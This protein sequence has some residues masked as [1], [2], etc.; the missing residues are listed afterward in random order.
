MN[1]RTVTAVHPATP[2]QQGF[3]LGTL[4]GRDA[5][6][7]EQSVFPL[8]GSLDRGQLDRA[9]SG[10]VA[11]HEILRTGFAWAL[12]GDPQQVVLAAG[13]LTPEY[14]DSRGLKPAAQRAALQQLLDRHRDAPFDLTRPPLLRL[15]VHRLND[16]RHQLVWTH[17]HVVLDGWSHLALA[18]ELLSRYAGAPGHRSAFGPYSRWL[19]CAD[20][21]TQTYW[22]KHLDGYRGLDGLLTRALAGFGYQETVLDGDHQRALNAF[23]ADHGL[24]LASVVV[25]CWSLIAG[26]QR[27]RVD[28]A[29]GVT[30]SGRSAPFTGLAELAGPVATTVPVR[31]LTTADSPVTGWFA[32]THGLLL[33][34]EQYSGCSSADLHTWSG[35]EP[36]TTLYDSV[37]ALANYPGTA[38]ADDY[39]AGLRLDPSGIASAGGRT[40]HPLALVADTSHGLRLRLVNDRGRVNDT[41]ASA[42]LNAMTRMLHRLAER[43]VILV[44]ELADEADAL[45][46]LTS[47]TQVVADSQPAAAAGATASLTQVIAGAYTEVLGRP[48]GPGTDFLTA[49]GHSLMALQLLHHL[50]TTLRVDLTLSDL[51]NAGAPA[52]LAARV[53]QILA[54]DAGMSSPPALDPAGHEP[55]TPFPMTGIQQAYWTGRSDEFDLGGVDSH[56]Y[57]EVDITGLDLDRLTEVWGALIDRHPMLRAVTTADGRQQILAPIP[58]YQIAVTDLR[59]RGD[60]QRHPMLDGIRRRLS[61][62]HRDPTRWPLFT[63]EAALLPDE[64]TRLFLSFDLLIGDALS[65]QILYREAR[66]LYEDSAAVL[67]TLHLTFADYVAHQASLTSTDRYLRDREYWQ[68]KLPSLPAPPQLPLTAAG[69][70]IT[71]QRFTRHQLKLR[72]CDDDVLRRVASAHG[73][74]LSTLLLSTFNETL[75]RFT[76]ST[77]FLVNVTVYNRPPVH[78]QINQIVGDFTSTV[79]ADVDLS[80]ATFGERVRDLQRTLWADLDH[81]LYSGVDVLRDLREGHPDRNAIAPVVFTSTLD[82]DP[83][84]PYPSNNFPGIVGYGIGQTPQVLLDY[85][86]YESGTD[87]II[88]LDAVDEAFPDGLVQD[89]LDN[90]AAAL[91]VLTTDNLAPHRPYLDVLEPVPAMPAPLGGARLLHEPFVEQATRH[92][93]RT[94]LVHDGARITYGELHEQARILA[95]RIVAAA[96]ADELVALLCR[97]GPGQA[98]SALATLLAGYAFVPLDVTWPAT[99]IADLLA[100]TGASLV[101]TEHDTAARISLP[102]GASVLVIDADGRFP[103][104]EQMTV[105]TPRKPG[106]VAYVIFT[107]GSTGRPKG[108][109]ISHKGALNTV[110]DINQRYTVTA[111]DTVLA[112]SA[113]TFDLAIYDLFGVLAA[114]GTVVIPTVDQRRDPEAWVQLIHTEQVTIW[115]SVPVLMDLLTESL[116]TCDTALQELRICLL[117]G[118]WIPVELPTKVRQQAPHCQVV[119]LGGATEGS[120]WSILYEIGDID[121]QWTS[122][123]YGAAMTG[124][125][126]TVLDDDLRPCP[127]WVPGQIHI[128]GHGT[129][130]GY[131]NAPELT[132]SS[133]LFDG[134]TGTR[135]YRTGD[136]GRTR[137]DGLIEFLGRRDDQV[138]IRGYRVE[139]R[140]VEAALR[141][142]TGVTQAAVVAVGGRTD[143]R[144]AAFAVTDRTADDVRSELATTL[145]AHMLPVKVIV[146]N[147]M[148]VSATSKLD[149][150][151]LARL[152][153]NAAAPD[154]P[155]DGVAGPAPAGPADVP[156]ADDLREVLTSVLTILPDLD[157]DLVALGLTSVDIIRVANTLERTC[158][159][160]PRLREFYRSPTLRF[161]LRHLAESDLMSAVQP[162]GRQPA[163]REQRASAPWNI[164]ELTDPQQRQRFR[165]GRPSYPPAPAARVL[166]GAE[167]LPPRARTPRRF[168]AQVVAAQQ[169]AGLL[170][171]LARTGTPAMFPYPSAGGL[172]AIRAH[173]HIRPGRVDQISAG[174]YAY[175]PDSADLVVHMPDIDLDENVHLGPVNRTLACTAAFTIFL[176]TNPADSAPLYGLDAEVL[177]LLNAGYIGQALYARAASHGLGLCPVHGVDFDTVRWMIPDGV[178]A[179]LLHTLV[180]GVSAHGCGTQA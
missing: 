93:D 131:W 150:N 53:H 178:N 68:A 95:S 106:D 143:R 1:D 25:G 50:R 151:V 56:L 145:P 6:F 153:M 57:T 175:H 16:E 165:A 133:F 120:I 138:K 166:P 100:V 70:G 10:L 126:V 96:P 109:T 46:P 74:T 34:A 130:L 158:G 116:P 64:I 8:I 73:C 160:R 80:A 148:P 164:P 31:L 78:P 81:I 87:L 168:T 128:G 163:P 157:D 29:V 137:T 156:G 85:Q 159:R 122:I 177:A 20:Q 35:I 180:G 113:F 154:A 119:S 43:D 15:A 107:S 147:E 61:H 11:D 105:R 88:N 97:P 30:V 179:V 110:L 76:G 7:V 24:T 37:V 162:A 2:V 75:R 38:A 114:G 136:W 12:A 22:T 101:L 3:L 83:A 58:P 17:H 104:K 155:A 144:L 115:N 40:R 14:V 170:A 135:L 60:A 108:V 124:Q 44:S 26:R 102:P 21:N 67:P 59:D 51:L 28:I 66:T 23:V 140:E 141:A 65:W 79:L 42:A 121:P 98:A 91:R 111:G 161:L 4:T 52:A 41:D 89:M 112:V 167:A 123:P 134:R 149:R 5:V 173:V 39:P 63:I 94:A 172:Y 132:A 71:R 86:T 32:E 99:R 54:G 174:M 103:E 33:A 45:T 19:A 36:G 18:H 55:R 62:P 82:L 90:H 13:S 152:A 171:V 92:P 129:A 117:S 127:A 169:L 125:L 47:G 142:I 9:C 84:G 27:G 69:I 72:R 146:L 139:I 118:D 49:G 48:A 77:R 176:T